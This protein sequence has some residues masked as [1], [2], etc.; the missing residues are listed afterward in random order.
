MTDHERWRDVTR[1]EYQAW[2][3]AHPDA[4]VSMSY[5]GEPPI[6]MVYALD[7]GEAVVNYDAETYHDHGDYV[8][9]K[10]RMLQRCP[11]CGR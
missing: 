6:K 1:D 11:V 4:D 5:I 8:E 7:G 10:W 2:R 3:E 9:V